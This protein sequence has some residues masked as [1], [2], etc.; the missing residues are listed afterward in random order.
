[1]ILCHVFLFERIFKNGEINQI[2]YWYIW[3]ASTWWGALLLYKWSLLSDWPYCYTM[4]LYTKKS[5]TIQRLVVIEYNTLMKIY[6]E[7][8][9]SWNRYIHSYHFILIITQIRKQTAIY[10]FIHKVIEILLRLKW[11]GVGNWVPEPSAHLTIS[12]HSMNIGISGLPVSLLPAL[13]IK[14]HWGTAMTI[15]SSIGYGLLNSCDRDLMANKDYNIY[16][17][18]LCRKQLLI[19]ALFH[20]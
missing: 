13:G 2:D 1:M 17:L 19:L 10:T 7:I 8:V 6:K 11:K 12:D 14:F 20:Q 16:I 5:I 4:K 3:I 15:C 18:V 9:W